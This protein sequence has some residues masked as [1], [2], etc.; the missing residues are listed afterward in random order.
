[1]DNIGYIKDIFT[2]ALF[3]GPINIQAKLIK[4][5]LDNNPLYYYSYRLD[6][7]MKHAQVTS[8]S[9]LVNW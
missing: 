5:T 6:S 2:D 3:L 7:P 1:M 4:D 9:T 8:F